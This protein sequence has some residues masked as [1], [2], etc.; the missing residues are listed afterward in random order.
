MSTPG[1]AAPTADRSPRRQ[2]RQ[3]QSLAGVA[4]GQTW[5]EPHCLIIAAGA[6]PR[7]GARVDLGFGGWT[8]GEMDLHQLSMKSHIMRN[9]CLSPSRRSSSLLRN[10]PCKSSP[11]S[12]AA[13]AWARVSRAR[14]RILPAMSSV[15]AYCR[16]S[17]CLWLPSGSS[18]RESLA[19]TSS[20]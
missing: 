16:V 18:T 17:S 19:H 15:I 1:F 9:A 4:E 7:L 8:T 5:R 11:D 6:L 2:Q 13:L 10:C 12:C 14:R 3:T 20:G